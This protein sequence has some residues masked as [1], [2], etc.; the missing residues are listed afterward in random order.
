MGRGWADKAAT[1]A[2]DTGV[3]TGT[4]AVPVGNP[5][6][7]E[8]AEMA[9]LLGTKV[10]ERAQR[11]HEVQRNILAL[12]EKKKTMS[13]G[14]RSHRGG[15]VGEAKAAASLANRA[16]EGEDQQA[17]REVGSGPRAEG[18]GEKDQE[19]QRGGASLRGL[20]LTKQ[21]HPHLDKKESQTIPVST[22]ETITL[23][24]AFPGQ[25]SLSAPHSASPAAVFP[26]SLGPSDGNSS[27]ISDLNPFSRTP[28]QAVPGVVAGAGPAVEA[29]VFEGKASAIPG[30][31]KRK[32]QQPGGKSSVRS[33]L[34]LSRPKR[35]VASVS[36]SV[37]CRPV[38]H[39]GQIRS[40]VQ[41]P[42]GERGLQQALSSEV[43]SS[44]VSFGAPSN[45]SSPTL[46]VGD[47]KVSS[48]SSWQLPEISSPSS[49]DRQGGSHGIEE[50]A[51]GAFVEVE[52][53]H[54]AKGWAAP[55]GRPASAA[56]PMTSAAAVAPAAGEA[57]AGCEGLPILPLDQNPA[58]LA[59]VVAAASLP[60]G[61]GQGSLGEGQCPRL[62]APVTATA[63][64][65]VLGDVAGVPVVVPVA[66][67]GKP[68]Q[69]RPTPQGRGEGQ[70]LPG[71]GISE[72]GGADLMTTV[73]VRVRQAQR[74]ADAARRAAAVAAAMA[75]RQQHSSAAATDP[76]APAAAAAAAAT[77][78]PET[79]IAVPV[80]SLSIP[81]S[82]IA[83][84]PAA[85]GKILRKAESKEAKL[86][87]KT[88]VPAQPI[89]V[90]SQN[91]A[92]AVGLGLEVG[93]QTRDLAAL[94]PSSPENQV[95]LTGLSALS[96]SNSVV[97]RIQVCS[98]GKVGPAPS[99]PHS[100][101]QALSVE[102]ED[103]DNAAE[104]HLL[105]AAVSADTATVGRHQ[106]RLKGKG[107]SRAALVAAEAMAVARAAKA[108]FRRAR[109]VPREPGW[110]SRATVLGS[111][112]GL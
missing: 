32:L 8:A 111:H 3:L 5:V 97:G 17:V 99:M 45:G 4:T 106:Q 1:A 19:G 35:R 36:E 56:S 108:D 66:S 79:C 6:L 107:V 88:S 11:L 78:M 16:E 15:G 18:A 38:N 102:R 60:S 77:S 14:S 29:S 52:Q 58:D 13:S 82:L 80:P 54:S 83:P 98:H 69:E 23:S 49:P 71:L 74:D 25:T 103:G 84:P 91:G 65:L 75:R 104:D 22:S 93:G 30:G 112:Q 33:G 85:S 67:N 50:A 63:V 48:I 89:I 55:I 41:G 96:Y 37:R 42:I 105:I 100:A 9:A 59:A 26:E 2:Q 21:Q 94:P 20:P 12:I 81:A 95:Q 7:R 10:T 53:F 40:T 47:Q 68:W 64:S 92:A 70:V 24:T 43:P 109:L 86:P 34:R 72:R 44:Q 57:S 28:T 39:P 51:A 62:K 76:H 87:D 27:T 110:L 31:G 101:T 73:L 90:L 61:T 46:N